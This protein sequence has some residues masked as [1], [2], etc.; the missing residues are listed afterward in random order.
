MRG[1]RLQP[2]EESGQALAE[3]SLILA[4]VVILAVA[5]LTIIGGIIIGYFGD[6]VLGFG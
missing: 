4:F 6:M 3:V 5:G 1:L 2:R